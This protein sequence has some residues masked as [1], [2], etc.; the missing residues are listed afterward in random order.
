V[1]LRRNRLHQTTFH[2]RLAQ[3]IAQAQEVAA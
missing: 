3:I 2:R 1:L